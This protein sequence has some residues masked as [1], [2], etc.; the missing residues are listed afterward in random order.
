MVVRLCQY[1]LRRTFETGSIIWERARHFRE[2]IRSVWNERDADFY[3]PLQS[4]SSRGRQE[5]ISGFYRV[6]N[7]EN[8]LEASVLAHLPFLDEIIIVYNDCSDATPEIAERLARTYPDKI[9]AYHYKPRVYPAMTREHAI[10]SA[11]SVHSLVNYYN[12][13]LAKT[14]RKTVVKIDADHL[15]VPGVF[16]D[17]CARVRARPLTT[18]HYMY[19]VNLYPCEQGVCVSEEKPFTHGYDVGFFPVSHKTRFIHRKQC[20]S[21]SLPWHMYRTR[22]SLGVQ[23]YHL[24]GYKKDGGFRKDGTLLPEAQETFRITLHPKLLSW[25]SAVTVFSERLGE[26][27]APSLDG[28]SLLS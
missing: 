5:G 27:P 1:V 21:L 17:T 26:V 3:T 13:A 24:K 8:L 23:F 14:T 7:E 18:M 4:I 22:R 25:E 2:Y 19:G 11:H 28:I 10:T 20:E 12:F 6:R 16:K 9:Q 15:P